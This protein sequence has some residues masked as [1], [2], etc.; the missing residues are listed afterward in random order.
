MVKYTAH[1]AT[2][3]L[4][5]IGIL[6]YVVLYIIAAKLYPGGSIVY[7]DSIGFDWSNN[8]WCN[9]IG[10]NSM[11]GQVNIAQPYALIGMIV[12]GISL[13]IFFYQYPRYFK[14]KSPW[15]SIVPISGITGSFFSMLIMSDYHDLT[16]VLAAVFGAL[17][18]V[19][20]FL[21][22][23]NTGL[24]Y[25]IWTGILCILLIALNGYI[26]FSKNHIIWLPIIQKITFAAVLL[27]VMCLNSMFGS[28]KKLV[29]MKK[30]LNR[31]VKY[32]S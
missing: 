3:F 9:L 14:L 17:S 30:S 11:N 15:N 25:F 26:Y 21:G 23:R 22:L 24:T 19:G 6:S 31:V 27:W 16:A 5:I 29:S 4:P 1:K 12:L 8:Y 13:G 10:D 18:I 20:I 32:K 2:R 7:P 28:E